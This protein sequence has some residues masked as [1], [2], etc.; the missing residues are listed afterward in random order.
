LHETIH[1]ISLY[2]SITLNDMEAN[3]PSRG[4]A[5]ASCGASILACLLR[6]HRI[7]LVKCQGPGTSH[8]R[9]MLSTRYYYPFLVIVIAHGIMSLGTSISFGVLTL[10]TGDDWLMFVS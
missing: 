6:A 4:L 5:L 2:H 7:Y 3:S 8:T 9:E 10:V 1:S